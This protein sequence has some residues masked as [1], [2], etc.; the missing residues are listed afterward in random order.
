MKLQQALQALKQ[1]GTAQNRKVYVR[2]G[3]DAAQV[4]GVSFAKLNLLV[5]QIK[6]DHDLAGKL[7]R[8][9]NYDACNLATKIAD[10]QAFT[11]VEAESWV[12]RV[13]N[14]L[15]AGLLGGL[16]ARSKYAN[17]LV[18]RWTRKKAE[19]VCATGYSLLSSLVKHHS[20]A[21]SDEQAAS[22]IASIEKEIRTS[23]NW[24]R[25]GMNWAL[26]ALGTYKESIR[27]EA[28]A[29]AERIGQVQVNHGKTNCKTPLAA[30]YILKAVAHLET[31]QAKAAKKKNCSKILRDAPY[32]KKDL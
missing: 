25:Y 28:L 16:L 3:A 17:T 26:I 22:F 12:K 9:G 13:N 27:Q 10:P 21:I 4:Y 30:P 29:T 23:P 20:H 11:V 18:I 24:T 31:K 14:S 6:C 7:W 2:H 1:Y 8:T 19:F 15:H 32:R 5:K